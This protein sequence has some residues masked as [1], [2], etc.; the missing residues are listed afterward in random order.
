MQDL[1]GL[2]TQLKTAGITPQVQISLT[3]KDPNAEG[4]IALHRQLTSAGIAPEVHIHV[5]VSPGGE[6]VPGE[7]TTPDAEKE[8]GLP[9]VVK[10]NKTNMFEFTRKDNAGKPIMEIHE[11]RLQLFS[12]AQLSVSATHKAGD[13]DSG[14]GIVVATG[15]VK[16]YFIVDCPTKREVE[17]FYIKQTD[18]SKT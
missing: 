13:K 11:P 10:V 12:G 1:D 3:P 6:V 2:L 5:H 7:E 8:V 16:F 9:A 17:G 4:V 15:G 14:D 18:V